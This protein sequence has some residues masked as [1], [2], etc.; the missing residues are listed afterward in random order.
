MTH[1]MLLLSPRNFVSS[2]GHPV[3]CH[4]L[5]RG[6]GKRTRVE[7]SISVLAYQQVQRCEESAR[8]KPR[9]HA[10]LCALRLWYR[11]VHA[12]CELSALNAGHTNERRSSIG[13]DYGTHHESRSMWDMPWQPVA[14]G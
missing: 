12:C 3:Y 5:Y 1:S 9:L 13:R 6:V 10:R 2:I 14:M 8:F 11:A 4:G 7:G